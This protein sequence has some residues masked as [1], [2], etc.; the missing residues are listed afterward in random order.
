[1]PFKAA[2]M[3]R[4]AFIQPLHGIVSR[5]GLYRFIYVVMGPL[6]PL[7]KALFPKSVTTTERVGQAM[8]VVAKKG[9]PKPVLENS[10]INAI[11]E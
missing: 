9:A 7:L 3:F 8:L 11:L 1:M 4:P 6:Y 10:D 5:T 2:Y